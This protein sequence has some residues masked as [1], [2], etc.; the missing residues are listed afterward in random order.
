MS[1]SLPT[2]KLLQPPE[3]PASHRPVHA[4]VYEL[5]GRAREYLPKKLQTKELDKDGISITKLYAW[6]WCFRQHTPDFSWAI[7][8]QAFVDLQ[9]ATFLAK[10]LSAPDGVIV[11]DPAEAT[12]FVVPFLSSTWCFLAAPKCW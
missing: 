4:P 12:Y 6:A 8:R 5:Q 1:A 11:D 10:L 2:L 9:K 7:W 3:S